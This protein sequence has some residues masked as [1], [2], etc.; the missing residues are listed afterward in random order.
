MTAAMFARATKPN[1]QQEE[2]WARLEEQISQ[3]PGTSIISNEWFSLASAEQ[4]EAFIQRLGGAEVHVVATIRNFAATVPAAWQE[5]LKLGH[6]SNFPEFYRAFQENKAGRWN[7]NSLDPTRFLPAWSGSIEPLH[8]HIVTVPPRSLGANVLW[9]RFARACGI[10]HTVCDTGAAKTNESIG[11][12]SARFLELVGPRL[13][14]AVDVESEPSGQIKWI[15]NYMSHALLAPLKGDK[16]AVERD[17]ALELSSRSQNVADELE[18]WGYR[19]HGDLD[20]FR[21]FSADGASAPENIEDSELW[22]VAAEVIPEMLRRV[23][24][25]SKRA[26]EATAALRRAERERASAV[27]GSPDPP[28][29]R[30][31]RRFATRWAL[32][33]HA[34]ASK[35]AAHQRVRLSAVRKA[36]ER[37]RDSGQEEHNA[38]FRAT[39]SRPQKTVHFTVNTLALK[40]GGLVK[41][42]RERANALAEQTD[43]DVWIEVLSFQ[44]TLDRD[45]RT[46]KEQG[47]LHPNVQ[48]RS[49]IYSLDDSPRVDVRAK[50]SPPGTDGWSREVGSGKHTTDFLYRGQLRY[51]AKVTAKGAVTQVD[52]F[53]DESRLVRREYLDGQGRPIRRLHFDQVTKAQTT[54]EYTGRDGSV[55][56]SIQPEPGTAHG[57]TAYVRNRQPQTFD[58]MGALYQH[59]LERIVAMD[60]APVI[61]SEF[62]ENPSNMLEGNFDDVVRA[63]RNPGALK[64]AVVHSNHLQPPYVRGAGVGRNW[65]RLL[66]N[67]ADFDTLVVLTEAQKD[68]LK[69]EYAVGDR[70]DVVPHAVYNVDSTHGDTNPNR[71]VVVSRTHPKKR[72]D[73]AIRVFNAISHRMPDAYLEIF[74]FGYGDAESA[75]IENLIA[76]FALGDKVRFMPF[77][78]DPAAIYGS[79]AFTLMTS[80]SEGFG[81]VLLESMSHGVPVLAYD[82]KYGP[83]DVIDDGQ[84]GYL[85]PFGDHEALAERAVEVMTDADLRDKL[86]LN[87]VETAGRFDR[88]AFV[89]SWSQILHRPPRIDRTDRNK[90]PEYE[91][92]IHSV[93]EDGPDVVFEVVDTL[94][95]DTALICRRHGQPDLVQHLT[96]RCWRLHRSAAPNDATELYYRLPADSRAIPMP[97]VRS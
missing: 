79:A 54:Q 46:L 25:E 52:H 23:R 31:E 40:R 70:V 13:R 94:P 95:A 62:R 22:A 89:S 69:A 30:E 17:F 87:A 93:R 72:M 68:D 73:E 41:A 28:D 1:R 61:C 19:V 8:V 92:V 11:A 4:A 86:K 53:D 2:T 75:K 42:V 60:R 14:D 10:A 59:A 43:L 80:A 48:V 84:N 83:S 36:Q 21:N 96:E 82:A 18:Q 65:T 38:T 7:W 49:V 56:L 33:G 26:D 85:V 32:R 71:V 20:E 35:F 50:W 78:D 47:Q 58:S 81:M 67:L 12:A 57:I 74:G 91:Q 64:V 3:W 29:S 15:R 24:A 39:D 66:E 63:I 90:K 45:V 44:R 76:E 6:G 5:W 9:E 77:T 37:R 51:R 55:F 88:K 27:S 16:I 97:A 34:V